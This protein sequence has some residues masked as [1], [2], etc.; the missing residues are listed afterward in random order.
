MQSNFIKWD[1]YMD[2]SRTIYSCGHTENEVDDKNIL[3]IK[4][5]SADDK[6]CI[7]Q[8][9]VC[10]VCSIWYRKNNLII[11]N[12]TQAERWLGI[13]RNKP[14]KPVEQPHK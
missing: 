9:A 6:K 4:S 5:V 8:I 10:E 14:A 1:N 12:E 7:E 2:R 13:R 11:D 3:K